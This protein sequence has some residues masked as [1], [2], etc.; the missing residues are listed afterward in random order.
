[1]YW[2]DDLPSGGCAVP[3]TWRVLYRAGD[4]WREVPNPKASPIGKDKF[5]QMAFD[6]IETTALRLDIELQ[7]VCSGGIL[8]WTVSE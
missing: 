4:Q 1:V 8:E 6:A 3:R 5:N 2:F 7:P